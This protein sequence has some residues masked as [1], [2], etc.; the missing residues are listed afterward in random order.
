[1]GTSLSRYVPFL[2]DS[3]YFF[4]IEVLDTI[5]RGTLVR[6][7]PITK[8]IQV[9]HVDTRRI[10]TDTL[11]QFTQE[12][13]RLLRAHHL[14]A[15][16]RMIVLLD[17]RRASI[18]TGTV[19]LMRSDP[20]SEIKQ[21]ELKNLVSRGVWKLAQTHRRIASKK[22]DIPE[23]R[24][25]LADADVIQVKLNGHRVVNPIGF[26]ARAV[27]F[28]CR[29]TFVD[30]EL[31]QK[32]MAALTDDN[33]AAIVEAPAALAGL[34]MRHNPMKDFLFIHVGA[35]ETVLYAVSQLELAYLDSVHW[36]TETLIDGV[37][38]QFAVD[39]A[40]AASILQQ[41][42]RHEV[43]PN[44]SQAIEQAA[45][46]E[47]AILSNA[48]ASHQPAGSPL[49]V[50]VYAAAPLPE[51]LFDPAF[52]RRLGLHLALTS[53]NERFIGEHTGFVVQWQQ[54]LAAQYTYTFGAL[55]AAIADVYAASVSPLMTTAAKQRARWL[56]EASEQRFH[57]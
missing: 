21:A 20:Q 10:G 5:L 26:A 39:A 29:G 28:C 50:Y 9:V 52:S 53:V 47:L 37:A 22:M 35:T 57:D 33:L 42:D 38:K 8:Q 11:D 36:G 17:Q 16:V 18:L 27:E 4:A 45:S 51:F 55:T 56:Q 19:T 1:M 25:Q 12:I 24:V 2:K 6:V 34:V 54:H 23:E 44:M 49:P 14:P 30:R 41:Y 15:T 31:L 46:G 32:T 48:I 7:D 40:A 43:S 13:P 3:D